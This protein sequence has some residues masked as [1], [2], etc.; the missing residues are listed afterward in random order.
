M[1]I[2]FLTPQL[3]YPP[4][5]GTSI[6]NWNIVKRLAA[7]HAIDVMTFGSPEDLEA[8]LLQLGGRVEVVPALPRRLGRR[9]LEIPFSRLP[10]MANRLFSSSFS[11]RLKTLVSQGKYD[12]LQVEGIEMARYL[13]ELPAALVPGISV[14]DDHNAEYLL[15]K[16]AYQSDLHIPTRWHA[17]FYSFVQWRKLSSF[18]R[19]VSLASRRV[20]AVSPQDARALTALDATIKPI[21]IP[22]GVDLDYYNPQAPNSSGHPIPSGMVMTGKMDFRPNVDGASWFVEEI[23]PLIQKEIPQAAVSLVGQK[24]TSRV[25]ALA[26]RPGVQITGWVADTR[27]YLAGAG[28]CIVPLRM[29]GGTRLKVL[30]AMAMGKA[31]VSTR[32]GAEGIDYTAG[33]DIVIADTPQDFASGA[34]DLLRDPALCHELGRNARRLVERC[35]DWNRLVPQFEDVYAT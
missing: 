30:E 24:P 6:R 22:N 35:Y 15:Q 18:E 10:D 14:F 1:R 11:K 32:L 5:Q 2:L 25:Q 29:G 21:V 17:A 27:P 23:L 3:P 20:V 34:V 16:S 9:A 13:L 12:A 4:H 8:P 7:K 26:S 19:R 28:L 33:R 31:T